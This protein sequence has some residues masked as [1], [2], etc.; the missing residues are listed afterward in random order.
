LLRSTAAVSG[1]L[2]QSST[3]L[4]DLVSGLNATASA[5]ASSDG[6]LAQSVS[7]LDQTLHALPPTLTALDRSLPPLQTLARALEPSLLRSPPVLTALTATVGQLASVLAPAQRGPLIASIKATFEQLPAILTQLA[8]SF[9]IG[10]QV[11]DCLQSHV[12]PILEQTVPD[13]SLS[14]GQSVLQDFLHFL[15]GVG[16]ASGSFDGNGPYT[17]FVVGG[18][19]NTLSGTLGGQQV[20]ATGVPGGGS[21][22]GSRP[23][24][25]G[26]LVPSDYR[27]DVPCA[28]QK[29]PSLASATGPVDLHPA[30]KP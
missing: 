20:V 24:W 22:Q 27:P 28:S 8:G 3:Q 6:A 9:P 19:S 5:L 12:L 10:R 26:D 16:G 2:A 7:G 30:G 1:T 14:T 18:G 15:P 13:G 21:L 29:V 25:V 11:T 4:A 23:Q 17:R